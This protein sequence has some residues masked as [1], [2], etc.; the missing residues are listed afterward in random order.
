VA[1]AEA[2]LVA[3]AGAV[4]AAGLEVP[5]GA[6]VQLGRAVAAL[7]AGSERS[8]YWAGRATLV[9]RPEDIAAYDRAFASF[10]S[11]LG[12]SPPDGERRAPPELVLD[13][14]EEQG[15]DAGDELEADVVAVRYSRRE[16]LRHMDF[17]ACSDDELAEVRRMMAHLRLTGAVRRSRRLQPSRGGRGRPD[18]G[19]TMRRSL[20]AGGQPVAWERSEPSTRARRLV[21]LLDVSGSM[22]LYSRALVR[23]AHAAVAG[24]RGVEAFALGT[25]MTRLTRELSSN[26]A[27][28][29]MA[30]A[31]GAVADW[32]GGTRL[33]DGLRAFNDGWGCR[34]VARGAVVIVLSDGWDRGDPDVLAEQ[35]ARLARVAHRVVWVNPLMASPGYAPLARGMVAALPYV[36]DFVEGH[37]LASLERLAKVLS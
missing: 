3:F 27:D 26:H 24:R 11:A 4:R 18:T 5:V 6:T 32:G 14:D 30:R 33:G 8:L 2:L 19:R 28:E 25:R 20:R 10:W 12:A 17:A 13:D 22:A 35:M 15:A 23:F 36:D 34:G 29:A 1:G 16:V 31:A 7:D 21:L 37:S 9:R